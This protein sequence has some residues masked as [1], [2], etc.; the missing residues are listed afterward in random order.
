MRKNILEMALL[1]NG[2]SSHIGGGLSIVDIVAT[3]YFGILRI[4]KDNPVDENRDRF[5]LSK[6]HGVLGFYT[7]LYEKGFISKDELMNFNKSGTFLFGHPI[8]NRSKGIEFSNDSLGMGLSLGVG[9]K[10]S[11]LIRKLNYKVYMLIGDGECNEGSIWESAM[12]ASH[13]NLKNI[14]AIV[15]KNNTA[16]RILRKYYEHG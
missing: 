11:G 10:L 12:S 16:N 7:A 1:G 4:E 14:V 8:M 15:D 3:L 5:I 2:K 6:G 13:Y 9:V